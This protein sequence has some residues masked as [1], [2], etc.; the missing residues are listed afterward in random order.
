[1]G[2][3]TKIKQISKEE[4][5]AM[6]EKRR[7]MEAKKKRK[8]EEAQAKGN[9][10]YAPNIMQ[11]DAMEAWAEAERAAALAHYLHTLDGEGMED[12][13]RLRDRAKKH[14]LAHEALWPEGKA[15]TLAMCARRFARPAEVT[16]IHLNSRT[17]S[18]KPSER[19]DGGTLG[20]GV[21]L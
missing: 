8:R 14:R 18:A 21:G 15:P 4:A 3:V 9:N 19:S 6:G 11:A 13:R 1:M 17:P 12:V 5:R 7:A 16:N 20:A 10:P 2:R